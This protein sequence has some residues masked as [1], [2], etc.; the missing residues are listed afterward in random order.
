MN[1]LNNQY[2]PES[3]LTNFFKVALGG[4]FPESLLTFSTKGLS[5]SEYAQE[6]I[7]RGK[8]KS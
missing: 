3:Q 2:L 5:N 8:G 1:L 4:S 7:K 6:I